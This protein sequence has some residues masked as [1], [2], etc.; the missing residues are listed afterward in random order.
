MG[1]ASDMSC[2]CLH[3]RSSRM[4]TKTMH[5]LHYCT[6]CDASEIAIKLD[7]IDRSVAMTSLSLDGEEVQ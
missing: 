6:V 4:T 7:C 1:N 5:L 3:R 2:E